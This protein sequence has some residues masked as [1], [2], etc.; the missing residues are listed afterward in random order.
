MKR[1][2]NITCLRWIEVLF[3]VASLRVPRSSSGPVNFVAI[4]AATAASSAGTAEKKKVI[5]KHFNILHG[6]VID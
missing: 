5:K 4:A 2:F 3:I 1:C 6:C